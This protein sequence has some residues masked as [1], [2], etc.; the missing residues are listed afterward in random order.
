MRRRHHHHH[1]NRHHNHHLYHRDVDHHRQSRHHHPNTP[2]LR[3]LLI[4]IVS[5]LLINIAKAHPSI[6]TTTL[7]S[8]HRVRNQPDGAWLLLQMRSMHAQDNGRQ[9]QPSNAKGRRCCS[10]DCRV[11]QNSTVRTSS[12]HLL[13]GIYIFLYI[14]H[15]IDLH[16]LL[17]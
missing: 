2:S 17:H 10:W 7:H 1:H 16:G 5:I 4:A 13:S 11:V 3:R 6:H 12:Y 9:R 15:I 14:W 8:S